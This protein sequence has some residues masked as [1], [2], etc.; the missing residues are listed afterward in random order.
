LKRVLFEDHIVGEVLGFSNFQFLTLN[1][2]VSVVGGELENFISLLGNFGGR[3]GNKGAH[4]RS[5]RDKGEELGVEKFDSISFTSK[6]GVDDFFGDGKSL[7]GVGVLGTFIGGSDGVLTT[8]EVRNSL[9]S[10]EDKVAINTLLSELLESG[11]S[12]LDH[13]RVVTS[14]LPLYL[15]G[16]ILRTLQESVASELAARMQSMQ[17]ASDNAGALSKKLSQEY[18]RAR[19]ASVTQEILEIVSGATALE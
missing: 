4:G 6:E 5:G 14:T 8:G 2:E 13:E 1:T 12:L 11:L 9:L 16:Q 3:E 19:Q 10:D 7:F 17:S 18:N 15:N